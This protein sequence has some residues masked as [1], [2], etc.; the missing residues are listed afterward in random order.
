MPNPLKSFL[1]QSVLDSIEKIIAMSDYDRKIVMDDKRVL[2]QIKDIVSMPED[3][4]SQ[5]I[6]DLKQQIANG[7]FKA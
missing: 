4:R 1:L 6:A 2:Q 5:V 3:K 7:S